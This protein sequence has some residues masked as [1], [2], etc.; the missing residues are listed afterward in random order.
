MFEKHTYTIR[1]YPM[2]SLGSHLVRTV[3]MHEPI[4][5]VQKYAAALKEDFDNLGLIELIDAEGNLYTFLDNTWKKVE[6]L[7]DEQ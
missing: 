2:G 4:S 3:I 7:N 6:K 5:G 1:L